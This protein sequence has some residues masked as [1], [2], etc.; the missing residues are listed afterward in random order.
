MKL[1]EYAFNTYSHDAKLYNGIADMEAALEIA[2]KKFE[3]CRVD[4]S[5][6]PSEKHF[7]DLA[8][9]MKVQP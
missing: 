1:S 4:T 6:T 7:A 2:R 8:E 9:R 5:G 3:E